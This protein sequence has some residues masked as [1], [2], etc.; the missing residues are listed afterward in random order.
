[1][2]VMSIQLAG[3]ADDD[4]IATS[5]LKNLPT[6]ANQLFFMFEASN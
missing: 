6:S 3:C 2:H 5:P 1:M 4:G